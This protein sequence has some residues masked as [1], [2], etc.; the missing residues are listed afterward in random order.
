MKTFPSQLTLGLIAAAVVTLTACGGGGSGGTAGTAGTN[1]ALVK[2]VA[3]TGLAIDGGKVTLSCTSGTTAPVTTA[4]DGSYSVD[5]SGVS[6]PCV[7]KVEYTDATGTHRLHS[8]VRAASNVNITPVTDLVVA[9]LSSTGLA[10]NVTANEVQGYTDSQISI[11]TRQVEALLQSKGV[12]TA[13][14]PIDVIGTK[15]EATHGSIKGDSHDDVLDQIKTQLESHKQTLDEVE[16]EFHSSHGSSDL[17]T[18]NGQTG[19]ASAGKASYDAMCSVCHGST[20]SDARNAA[21]TLEAVRK[22]EGGM[23]NLTVSQQIADNIATYLTYGVSAST[24]STSTP[25]TTP[26]STLTTQ[27]VT[28]SAPGQQTLGTSPALLQATAS[29]GL[30]V[31]FTSSTSL[32]CTVSATTLTLV[33]AGNCTVT[34]SQA[35]NTSY[36]AAPNQTLSFSVIDPAATS[37]PVTPPATTTPIQLIPVAA[38]GKALYAQCAGC[39]GAAAAGGAKV[40]NGANSALTIL[41]AITS[42]LGGMRSLSGLTNQNLAD[43]A[44]YLATPTI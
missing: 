13:N 18:S 40:L 28:F 29:S 7:A 41:N 1:A 44:A 5:V 19:D 31:S 30:P 2:G 12:N 6:L 8:L 39:H 42:N 36:A 10:S 35:G 9:G 38:T 11:A 17:G 4:A 20:I 33:A 22:N 34:A 43:L 23:G 37:T 26:G 24:G 21:K 32:V 14:L 27:T 3:A 15:F 25:A 16:N